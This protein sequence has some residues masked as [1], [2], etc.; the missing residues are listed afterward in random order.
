MTPREK[1]K[2]EQEKRLLR[3]AAKSGELSDDMKAVLASESGRRVLWWLLE[4]ARVFGSCF[5]GSS[6]TFFNE[7]ARELGL[8]LFNLILTADDN[9]FVTMQREAKARAALERA[10]GN[11]TEKN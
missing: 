11:T 4:Q 7:G 9:A 10:S 5:T 6:T 3:E 2:A 1:Q 8:K